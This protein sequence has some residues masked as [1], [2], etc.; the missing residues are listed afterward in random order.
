MIVRDAAHGGIASGAPIPAQWAGTLLS[1]TTGLQCNAIA[2]WQSFFDVALHCTRVIET[3]S[4]LRRGPGALGLNP[5]CLGPQSP[6]LQ[7]CDT[8]TVSAAA[9]MAGRRRSALWAAA[10]LVALACGAAA[11]LS[12]SALVLHSRQE[13]P[14]TSP[15]NASDALVLRGERR[16]RV[17]AAGR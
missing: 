1:G 16:R 13:L 15:R 2:D 14:Q 5:P 6:W 17:P 12:T 9:R 8:R 3:V 4:A 11:G 7:P 10:L